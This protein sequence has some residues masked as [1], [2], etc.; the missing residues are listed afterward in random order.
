MDSLYTKPRQRPLIHAARVQTEGSPKKDQC[1]FAAQEW[2]E[3]YKADRVEASAELLSVL[4][5]VRVST[6][7]IKAVHLLYPS[8]TIELLCTSRAMGLLYP[9]VELL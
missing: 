2:V 7:R 8:R 6:K 5:K 1:A 3:R 4:V 9:I